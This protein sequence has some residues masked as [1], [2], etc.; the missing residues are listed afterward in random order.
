[1]KLRIFVP[2][3]LAGLTLLMAS[4]CAI[5]TKGRSEAVVI[6]STPA[7]AATY[8]NGLEIGKTPLKVS[9]PRGS[10]HTVEVRKEGF[11]STVAVLLPVANEYE[12]RYFRWG[13]DYDLGAMTDFDQNELKLVMA[14]GMAN[15]DGGDRFEEMSYRVLQADA[16]LASHE[17]S[18]QDHKVIVARIVDFYTR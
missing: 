6:R 3:L 4:G 10:A 13:I 14:P 2:A 12:R 8:V 11:E 9:L 5:A 18:A 15:A 7:G 17:I 16:L 1:M